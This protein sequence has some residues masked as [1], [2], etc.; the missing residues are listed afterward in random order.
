MR[1]KSFPLIIQRYLAE[2]YQKSGSSAVYTKIL[3]GSV[4]KKW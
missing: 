4:S 3:S 2:V 1:K